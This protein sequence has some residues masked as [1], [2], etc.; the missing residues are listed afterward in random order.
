M[1]CSEL[2]ATAETVPETVTLTHSCPVLMDFC[3]VQPEDVDRVLGVMRV[4]L[5]MLDP[6]PSSRTT[7]AGETA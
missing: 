5:C 2:D 6:C 3:F 7:A 1:S 4:K